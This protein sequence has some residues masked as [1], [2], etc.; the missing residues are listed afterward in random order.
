MFPW[1]VYVLIKIV[2]HLLSS[3]LDLDYQFMD[4]LLPP[5][6]VNAAGVPNYFTKRYMKINLLLPHK[7]RRV[8]IWKDNLTTGNTIA[9]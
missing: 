9:D 8:C 3:M 6:P 2:G 5:S 1:V 4:A 7:K